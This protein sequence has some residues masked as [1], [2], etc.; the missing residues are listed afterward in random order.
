MAQAKKKDPRKTII[1][2]GIA[3]AIDCCVTMP[4]DTM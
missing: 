2:G 4:L 3:G 1:A